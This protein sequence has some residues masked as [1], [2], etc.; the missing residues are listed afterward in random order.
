MISRL[1]IVV[2]NGHNYVIWAQYMKT[3]SKRK[4]LWQFT[5]TRV[6]N[7]KD[8]HHKFFIDKMKNEDIGVIMTYIF[9]NS[10]FHISGIDFSN[11]IWKKLK[12]VFDKTKKIHFIQI[13]KELISLDTISFERIEYYLACEKEL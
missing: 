6:A 3:L 7:S 13:E 1:E 11:D 2:I 8:D 4:V 10:C 12:T 5:K 9:R